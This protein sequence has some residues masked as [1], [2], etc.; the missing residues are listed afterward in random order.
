MYGVAPSSAELFTLKQFDALQSLYGQAVHVQDPTVY[1]YQALGEALADGSDTG[2]TTFKTT[3]GP[4]AIPSDAT[5][6]TQAYLNVFGVQ[7]SPAQIQVFVNQVNFFKSIYTTS[8]AFGGNANEIDLQARGAVYGQML[9]VKAENPPA[10]ASA[11]STS[12][13]D[14]N[15][16][17]LSGQHDM[18]HLFV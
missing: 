18:T 9:G 8:G 14:S 12:I 17:G 2:A 11:A 5:F 4:A 6:A 10:T 16:V 13:D 15:L 3:W 1:V 7:G